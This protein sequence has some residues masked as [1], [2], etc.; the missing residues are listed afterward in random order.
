MFWIL[1]QTTTNPWPTGDARYDGAF[2]DYDAARASFITDMVALGIHQ[3]RASS[4][5]D[6][7]T[8][9]R[10][11]WTGPIDTGQVVAEWIP[12][13]DPPAGDCR[14][15]TVIRLCGEFFREGARDGIPATP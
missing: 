15:V 8:F 1:V 3:W 12:W 7:G 5:R 2:D 9:E 4:P 6:I 11:W 13:A 10:V 14:P